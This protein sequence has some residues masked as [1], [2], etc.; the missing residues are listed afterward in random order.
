MTLAPGTKYGPYEIVAPLGAG[1]MGEVYRARDSRLRREVAIKTLPAGL[2]AD[3]ERLARLERE[4][5]L[6]AALNHPNIAAI[7]GIE[8]SGDSRFLVLELVEGETLAE[9]LASGPLPVEDALSI[10]AQIAYGLEAAHD[11]GVIHRDLKPANVKIRPDG[12]VKI[13]DLGLAR[14]ME[15]SAGTDP[16]LSPTITSG[17]TAAGVILGT[18]A[19]MSP[20]QARGKALDKRS[21]IFSFGCVLY[22]CLTG[23]RAFPG[24]TVSDTLAAILR[25]EPDWKALPAATPSAIRRLLSRCLQKDAKRRLRD[26][27]DARIEIEEAIAAP[28]TPT[29]ETLPIR[30]RTSAPLLW[31]LGG[32]IFGILAMFAAGRFLPRPVAQAPAPVRAVL[33]LPEGVALDVAGRPAIAVSPD[34]STVVFR[35]VEQGVPRL[36]RRRLDG[37]AAKP[38]AGTEGGSNPFFSPDGQWLGFFA[39][40][41]LKKVPVAGGSPV[42]VTRV[43]PVTMGA[44]WGADG[45]ILMTLT[46]NGFLWSVPEA[47]GPFT[48]FTS[49]DPSRGEHAHLWPQ[50]LP[51]GRT[52]L[53]A[54]VLGQDSQDYAASQIVALDLKSGRRKILIEGS[55]FA[56]YAADEIVF[57][58]GGSVFRAAFDLS[59]L[60]V[61]GP[62]IPVAERIAIDSGNGVASFEVTRD[63]ALVY[64]DGPPTVDRET[65]VLRLDRNG[66]ETTLPIPAGSYQ[67]LRLSPDEKTL[68]LEK[69]AAPMCRLFL[70][71]LERNVLSPLTTEPGGFFCAVWSPDARRVAYTRVLTGGPA[72]YVKNADGSGQP[73]RLTTAPTE[74]RKIAEFASSWSPDGRTFAYSAVTPRGGQAARDLWVLSLDGKR[75]GRP[76]FTTPEAEFAPAFSPDGRWIAYVSEGSGRREVYVRPFPG[77]GGVVKIS[78]NGGSEPAW[79]REGRELLYRQ[80]NEFFTV[81]M[82]FSPNLR[83]GAP[84]VLFSAD[85]TH[86]G[87]EEKPFEYAVS[88]DGNHIYATRAVRSPEPERRLAIVTNWTS[89]IAPEREEK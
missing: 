78:T 80:G 38:I 2:A 56:R 64:A 89:T 29:V 40:F 84:R 58:R 20:E 59:R 42:G 82:E 9:R 81:E 41:E 71:D 87:G 66:K 34:G 6:L 25:A 7:Y 13:L 76:W 27:G 68:A 70:Y 47:G 28:R 16:S 23:K 65:V 36:Y 37:S 67:G 51:D 4:A 69:C 72:L 50:I 85:L 24:E 39:G 60:S 88:S 11:A 63:G 75:V 77:P 52:I 17:G 15:T 54:T 32:A 33:P 57:V 18:A 8:D 62:A 61:T 31:A 22:E 53:L 26:M 35:A 19:Y 86:G 73:E 55:P 83:V 30:S 79:T 1:G 5:R 3:P 21:D 45:K 14:G 48:P 10:C 74:E 12:S 43:P 49:L 46:P 44:A